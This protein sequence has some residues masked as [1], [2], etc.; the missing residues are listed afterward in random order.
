MKV[1]AGLALFAFTALASMTGAHAADGKINV[2]AAENFYG[3]VARSA[4]TALPS[5][6]S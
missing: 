2:V 5:P 4:A 1:V 6:A 3:D